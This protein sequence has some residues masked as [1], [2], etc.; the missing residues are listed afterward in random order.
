MPDAH[1]SPKPYIQRVWSALKDKHDGTATEAIVAFV[2]LHAPEVQAVYTQKVPDSVGVMLELTTV[3]LAQAW[4]EVHRGQ[5]ILRVPRD[6]STSR[7]TVYEFPDMTAAMAW[8][9][10]AKRDLLEAG[11]IAKGLDEERDPDY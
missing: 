6:T 2:D 1:W 3:H 9:D 4:A 5:E 8:V 11:W 10:R 7:S